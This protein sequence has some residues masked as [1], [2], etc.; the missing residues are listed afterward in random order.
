MRAPEAE[1]DEVDLS[2]R[3]QAAACR[4]R[5]DGARKRH[6][7][8]KQRLDQLGFGKRGTDL[9]QGLFGEHHGPLLDRTH[10]TREAQTFERGKVVVAKAV[11]GQVGE[12]GGVE[13]Q[14][15]EV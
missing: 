12:V 6:L 1:L 10:L 4:L 3:R 15:F 13:A 7:V 5:R 8:E 9:E 2:C 11:L 14:R